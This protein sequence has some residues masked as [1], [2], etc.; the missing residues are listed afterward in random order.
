MD[1][2]EQG[3]MAMD[4]RMSRVHGCTGATDGQDG[5]MSR[6]HGCTGATDLGWKVG[7]IFAVVAKIMYGVKL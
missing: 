6:A 7:R 3:L 4:A 1:E 2:Q 5:R